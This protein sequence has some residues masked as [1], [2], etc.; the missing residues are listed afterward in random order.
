MNLKNFTKHF[1][2]IV[3]LAG[4]GFLAA[5][6][7]DEPDEAAVKLYEAGK[8][9][10]AYKKFQSGVIKNADNLSDLSSGSKAVQC[11]Y[12]AK[13]LEM[14]G[15]YEK[16][17]DFKVLVYNHAIKYTNLRENHT[18]I[19]NDIINDSQV[20]TLAAE[21]ARKQFVGAWNLISAGD[22]VHNNKNIPLSSLRDKPNYIMLYENGKGVVDFD[23]SRNIFFT[24]EVENNK[25]VFHFDS[26]GA[27][28]VLNKQ[29]YIALRTGGI[30]TSLKPT[31]V[32][33]F[34]QKE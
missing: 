6:S 33:Y 7:M 21:F 17:G 19:Y 10:K 4:F 15:E 3:L 27:S 32:N 26:K 23:V 9:D 12:Y 2:T 18:E 34:F 24:W 20:R 16:A 5:G 14:E 30:L 22:E 31:V 11:Y 13:L 29:G 1:L 25:P 8:Y 28:A